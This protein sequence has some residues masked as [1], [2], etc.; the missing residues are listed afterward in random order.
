MKDGVGW[1]GVGWGGGMGWGGLQ[2]ATRQCDSEVLKGLPD[3]TRSTSSHTLTLVFSDSIP[4]L[5]RKV[6]ER[7]GEKVGKTCMVEQCL[8]SDSQCGCKSA[9]SL[10]W[11]TCLRGE[12]R[13]QTPWHQKTARKSGVVSRRR[14]VFLIIRCGASLAEATTGDPS[15]PCV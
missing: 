3:W 11:E 12:Y 15:A 14:Y 7:H 8:H 6:R 2:L 10:R 5:R 13:D 1:G 4:T 9:A